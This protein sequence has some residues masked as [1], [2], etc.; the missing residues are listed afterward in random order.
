MTKNYAAPDVSSAEPESPSVARLLGAGAVPGSGSQHPSGSAFFTAPKADVEPHLLLR[1][2]L[3]DMRPRRGAVRE[4]WAGRVSPLGG[5][6]PAIALRSNRA[7][8]RL[9]GLNLRSP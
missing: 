6:A 3:L 4:P 2:E 1:E 8:R 9:A 5:P 7:G